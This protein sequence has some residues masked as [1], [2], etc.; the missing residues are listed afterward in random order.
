M[1]TFDYICKN[2]TFVAANKYPE[3]GQEMV[4]AEIWALDPPFQRY[5]QTKYDYNVV[6]TCDNACLLVPQQIFEQRWVTRAL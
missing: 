3:L 2:N 1:T 4:T 6:G 5:F